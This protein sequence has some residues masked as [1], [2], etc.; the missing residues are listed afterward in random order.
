MKLCVAGCS[1]SDYTKV[2]KVWGEYLAEK[3]NV[4]YIHEGA[5]CGS[6]WR[7]WRQVCSHV[8]SGKLTSADLLIVQYTGIDR[9][10]FWSANPPMPPREPITKIQTQEPSYDGGSI[11]RYKYNSHTWQD[12]PEEKQLFE[13]YERNFVNPRFE[14][15]NF[16]VH[17]NMFQEFLKNHGIR[18]IFLRVRAWYQYPSYIPEFQKYLFEEPE[19]FLNDKTTWLDGTDNGHLS[20]D[21]HSR[22]ADMIHQHINVTGILNG[23]NQ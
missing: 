15:D 12:Y 20:V 18:T 17:S 2:D 14:N 22:F 19:E 1:F 6:N 16:V 5:G 9:R 7:I 10:E 8:L 11:I 4:E 13:L 21:G 23:S 3:L